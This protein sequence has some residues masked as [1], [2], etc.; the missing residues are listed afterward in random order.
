MVVKATMCIPKKG[1]KPEF[2]SLNQM[3]IE[4]S[5]STANVGFVT[6][7]IKKQWGSEYIIVTIDGLEIDDSSATQG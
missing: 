7:A 2:Q 6:E 3:Y 4:L 5:E 1:I